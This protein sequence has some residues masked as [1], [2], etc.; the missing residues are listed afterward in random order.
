MSN[1]LNK[2]TVKALNVLC[3]EMKL[4]KYSK[5][6]KKELIEFIEINIAIEG[7]KEGRE[8]REEGQ[9][10]VLSIPDILSTVLRFINVLIIHYMLYFL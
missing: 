9:E 8:E 7:Q 3:K 2:M 5:L 4:K 10:N 1:K 6:R